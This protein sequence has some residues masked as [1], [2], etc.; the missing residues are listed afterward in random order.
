MVAIVYNCNM[1]PAESS[2]EKTDNESLF[3][4]IIQ[5]YQDQIFR[6]VY[7]RV[8]SRAIALDITQDVFTKTWIYL[9]AG[10][11][12]DYPEAF[13]YRTARNAVI[14]FY[15]KSKSASLDVLT[16]AGFDP[17]DTETTDAIDKQDDVMMVRKM[18]ATLDEESQQ[19]IFLRYTEEKSIEEIA[20]IFGKNTNSMTVRIHRIMKKLREEHKK[21]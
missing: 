17:H 20:Q 3:F 19:I 2:Q 7:F 10:K 18:V 15:K 9:S 5:S 16:E 8:S 4:D 13:V 1:D 14:D 21:Q 11:R 12:I 6:F